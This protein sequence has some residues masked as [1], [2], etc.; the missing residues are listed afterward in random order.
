MVYGWTG[1]QNF[2]IL[3]FDHLLHEDIYFHS[4]S[5]AFGYCLRKKQ[6]ELVWN[7]SFFRIGS[8]SSPRTTD[9]NQDGTL[10]IV[11]GAAGGGEM[12]PT[13]QGVLAIDGNSGELIWQQAA[14]ASVHSLPGQYWVFC[15]FFASGCMI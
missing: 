6:S 12:L 9:L 15:G 5:A 14:N 4:I 1:P 2:S 11:M 3:R 13:D 7:Q 10:D 8:Q